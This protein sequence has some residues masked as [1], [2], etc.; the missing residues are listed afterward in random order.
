MNLVWC[1]V[2]EPALEHNVATLK[3]R[4]G[5]GV[6]LAAVV[7]ANAYGHGL[8]LAARAF[9]RGGADWLCVNALEELE[10]LRG[11]GIR[12]PVYVMG[13]VPLQDLEAVLRLDGR[14]VA[15]NFETI[16][17]LGRA[18]RRTGKPARVHLKLETGNHRQ[19]VPL[20][21]LVR[22]AGRCREE[23]VEVEGLAT[24]FAD[25]EDTTDHTFALEQLRRFREGAAALVAE[26]FDVPLLHIANSAATILLAETQF[27][28]VR[29]GIA[30]YGLWP[31]SETLVSALRLG[32]GDVVLKPALTWKTRVAQVKTVPT[33]AFIGYGCTYK[34]THPTRLAVLPVGYYDGYDRKLSNT[35]HVLIRGTRAPVRGRV[36]M[37]MIMVDVTDIPDVKVEDEVVLLGAQGDEV[38]T[39]E[40]MAGWIGTINYEVVTRIAG[41]VPRIPKPRQPT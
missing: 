19:G 34:T 3:R 12:A 17:A 36:C 7:K 6:K 39:A 28:M 9:L 13:Y 32:R 5:P 14:M 25:I 26:G 38:V 20:K 16:D 23:G 30:A 24:H 8:V 22:L 21:E 35:G 4:L 37:N 33:G 10:A 18:M 15:Y 41:H 31:S 29:T 2:D 27:G 1:E 40:Q 11:D